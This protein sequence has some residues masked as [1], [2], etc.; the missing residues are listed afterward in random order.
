MQILFSVSSNDIDS[1]ELEFEIT[2]DEQPFD[3]TGKTLQL[4]IQNPS[5]QV[6]YF[7]LD[8][9]S[10][11][12]GKASARLSQNAYLEEGIHISE[13]YITDVDQTIVTSPFYF[14]SWKSIMQSGV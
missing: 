3:L 8:S 7:A 2:Q 5:R 6:V 11:I 9:V 12:E 4:A 1:V 13:V 10:D 14:N